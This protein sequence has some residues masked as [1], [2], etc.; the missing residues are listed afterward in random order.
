MANCIAIKTFPTFVPACGDSFLRQQDSWSRIQISYRAFNVLTRALD[1]F[2]PFWSLVK[3]FGLK[4]EPLD[5]NH[6][7]IKSRFES[8]A[9]SR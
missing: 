5:E 9:E 7:E 4:F 6:T 1:V 3:G 2:P 8:N